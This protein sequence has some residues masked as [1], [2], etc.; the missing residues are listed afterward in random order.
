MSFLDPSKSTLASQS[1]CRIKVLLFSTPQFC[2]TLPPWSSTTPS[3]T[4][5]LHR[6]SNHSVHPICIRRHLQMHY[7][8]FITLALFIPDTVSHTHLWYKIFIFIL[9]PNEMYAKKINQSI[10]LCAQHSIPKIWYFISYFEWPLLIS[11]RKLKTKYNFFAFC[12]YA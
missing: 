4:H 1:P 12:L 10:D 7:I 8:H 6:F 2:P 11:L 9:S 5:S 3:H